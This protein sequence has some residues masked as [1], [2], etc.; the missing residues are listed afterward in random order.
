MDFAVPVNHRVEFEES[1]KKDEYLDLVRESKKKQTVGHESDVYIYYNWCSWYCHRMIVKGTGGHENKRTRGDY[2]NDCVIEIGQSTEES[3]RLVETCCHSN[4]SE[5]PSAN[6]DVKKLS[7]S[8]NN[9]VT[10]VI[11][12]M[13]LLIK[14][15]MLSLR[16]H[17]DYVHSNI[18][19]SAV[20]YRKT[21][22]NTYDSY[23]DD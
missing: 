2:P 20:S 16:D 21:L 14:I 23:I 1:E 12:M 4:S 8:N 17:K 13:K 22:I 9:T 11:K 6:A 19:S 7:R 18:E 5:R 3:W 10:Q 15:S